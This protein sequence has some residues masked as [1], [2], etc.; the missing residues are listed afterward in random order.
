MLIPRNDCYGTSARTLWFCLALFAALLWM[1]PPAV[2]AGG[3]ANEVCA[4]CHDEISEAFALTPHG[5]YLSERPGMAEYSCEACHGSAAEHVEEGDPDKI[6][7]PAKQDQ[8]GSQMCLTCH[9]DA[10]FDD[11]SFAHHN[12][13]DLNCASCHTVHSGTAGGMKKSTPDLCYDCHSDVRAASL[14][15]S[16]HPV[17]E[18]KM[19]CQDCHNPH[20]GQTQYT[21]NA[22]SRELCFSCHADIEGPFVYEHAPVNE[23]CMICHSP[24]GTVADKLLKQ[25]EPALCLNCHPMHFHAAVEGWDGAFATPQTPERAGVSTPDGWKLGMLTK[26]TQCHTEVH[27]SDHPSQAAS[28]AGNALTR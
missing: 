20:G 19:S 6:I 17:A 26:C 9:D 4:A 16:H 23:D 14:M 5:R 24:H 28:T 7:N 10:E 3:V 21:L 1:H 8:F 18:G 22:S 2:Q 12:A 13:A 27:G 11:W 25:T 15:P